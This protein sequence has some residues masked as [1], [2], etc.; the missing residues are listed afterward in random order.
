MA[1]S[2]RSVGGEPQIL[3]LMVN[4]NDLRFKVGTG[5]IGL[6]PA[7]LNSVKSGFGLN[8]LVAVICSGFSYG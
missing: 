5:Q 4:I 1:K 3:D 7:Q 6:G 8:P 2:G